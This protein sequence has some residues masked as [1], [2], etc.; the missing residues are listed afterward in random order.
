MT[1]LSLG[2]EQ[3]SQY[4]LIHLCSGIF[5]YLTL[6]GKNNSLTFELMKVW[7]VIKELS[8]NHN[9]SSIVLIHLGLRHD[10]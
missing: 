5:L 7:R 6:R 3:M 9:P 10:G 4:H 2:Q 8:I 1:N